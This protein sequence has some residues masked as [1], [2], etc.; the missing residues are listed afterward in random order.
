MLIPRK[1]SVVLLLAILSIVACSTVTGSIVIRDSNSTSTEVLTSG[2]DDVLMQPVPMN[3]PKP[4]STS[5]LKNKL[6]KQ[7]EEKLQDNDFK[8]AIAL[9]ERGL[10]IDRKE[11]YFYQLLAE[12]Y[13][14]L[15]NKTQS[16]YFAKQGL[17]YAPKNSGV[18]QRLQILAQ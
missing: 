8:G 1:N 14:L 17:R 10:R 11:A 2:E 15:G 6:I 12:A 16:V 3:K 7:S 4:S 13:E 5:P 18:Y 9:A